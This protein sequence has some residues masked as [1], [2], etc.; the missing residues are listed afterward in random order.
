[1]IPSGPQPDL[2]LSSPRQLVPDGLLLLLTG[3]NSNVWRIRL[4]G[5]SAEDS[6]ARTETKRL[7]IRPPT[8]IYLLI[9]PVEIAVI[10]PYFL[11]GELLQ[12]QLRPFVSHFFVDQS[13]SESSGADL[14]AVVLTHAISCSACQE[15]DV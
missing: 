15:V 6:L 11:V 8:P 4:K 13:L 1:M 9:V 12:G 14:R 5:I 7:I 2:T 3:W 10:L